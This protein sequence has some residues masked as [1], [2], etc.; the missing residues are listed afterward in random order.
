[1]MTEWLL[2][3]EVK[4]DLISQLNKEI[5]I[6]FINEKTEEK[7]LNALW[8]IICAVISKKLGAQ[9]MPSGKGSYGKKRG[10][11]KKKKVTF[12]PAKKKKK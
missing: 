7:L 1:M 12:K 4:G 8:K 3:D 5:D 9:I 11:P 6:P 10:R 2:D